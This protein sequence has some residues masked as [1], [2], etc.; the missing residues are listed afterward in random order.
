MSAAD[1]SAVT[2]RYLQIDFGGFLGIGRRQVAVPAEL[3]DTHG[4]TV[5]VDFTREELRHAPRFDPLSPM[6]R[7]DEV[8]IRSHFGVPH[9]WITN[10]PEPPA[11]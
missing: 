5:K 6:S 4:W 2:I 11:N 9:Y 3:A 1:R 7:Q 10:N 8:N